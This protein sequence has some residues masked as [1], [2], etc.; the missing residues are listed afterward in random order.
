MI[1]LFQDER[2]RPAASDDHAE[3]KC[4]LPLDT[5]D[6]IRLHAKYDVRDPAA[7]LT[8]KA[9]D[10]WWTGAHGMA[11]HGEQ[12]GTFGD[13]RPRSVEI[14][15]APSATWNA[16]ILQEDALASVYSP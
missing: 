14:L 2:Y 9:G 3:V 1:L 7:Q 11:R 12:A 13:F 15:T 16:G 4:G 6:I 8:R 5:G 10:K